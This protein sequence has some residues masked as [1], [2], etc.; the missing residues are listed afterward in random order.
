[1]KTLKS[2]I[3]IG[4]LVVTLNLATQNMQ[5]GF[6]YLETG[7]YASAEQFFNTILKEYPKSKTARICYGRAVGL[8]GNTEIALQ[9]FIQLLNDYP[10][11]F[12]IKLNYAESLLWIKNF[13]KAKIYYKNLVAEN[14]KSFA[15]L[16]GYANTLS[17]L[18]NYEKALKLVNKALEVSPLNPNALTSKKYIY[19]GYAYQNQQMQHYEKAESLLTK[20]L[21]F[22]G[23]DRETLINLAN[24]YLVWE[25]IESA[26]TIYQRL[27][28]DPDNTIIA[29]NGLALVAHLNGKEKQALK[30]ST[31]AYTKLSKN[32]DTII[33]QQTNERFAQALIWN[34]KYKA[35]ATIIQELI[36]KYNTQNWVLALRATLNIYK[37]N[38]KKSLDDYNQILA[39][40]STSFDG[41]LGKVNV[42]KALG[43]Y[44]EAY[45]S[46]EK[47]LKIY[48]NQKDVLNFI[49]QLDANFSPKLDN[50]TSYSFD[51]G[52]NRAFMFS[53]NLTYPLS[54][55]LSIL[56]NY[57]YRTT[58][59][60]ITDNTANSNNFSLGIAYN[61]LPNTTF[62][63]TAG[64]T[65]AN[66]ETTNFN[67]WLTDISLNIKA[68]KLQNLDIGF[69]RQVESFNANLLDREL[70]Q[71]N[72]Y[73]N[74]NLSTNV[75]LGWYTQF[76]HTAQNDGNTRNLLFTSLYYNL[77]PKPG[78]KLG[79]NYQY[80]TFKDQVPTVYFS[81]EQFNA[82]EVFI[83][84]NKDESTSK[85]KDWFYN[86]TG[87]FGYQFIENEPKQTTYRFQGVF[88]YKFSERN[89]F[90]IYG[91]HS[92][93]ASTTAAGFTFTEIGLQFKWIAIN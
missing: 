85:P 17:N 6:I 56:G 34:R 49:K 81:P 44:D 7:Q 93:I 59:N 74:Y 78:L 40:D 2:L 23:D 18:K 3:N 79:F 89:S 31:E 36:K 39:N 38:F 90:N 50:K 82:Y 71:N 57:S 45:T 86:L 61:I 73:T 46:A 58:Q 43:R 69:K 72:F 1:M 64:L 80:L 92:N 19:L 67:Q 20:N 68:F 9:L 88:G 42:L 47:T 48:N 76:M 32:T 63:A 12:E 53:T 84:L 35:A 10:N 60:T 54:T 4:F 16:L 87:A 11:D 26:K 65:T 70:V 8:N 51:N 52:N 22:F 25:K 30:L 13:D 27:A 55:K 77:L 29:L 33:T 62:K 83:N 14:P 5:E 24:L 41:N 21:E 15:A 91:T 37:S 66:A 75:N 28:K